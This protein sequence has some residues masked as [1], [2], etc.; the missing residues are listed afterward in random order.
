V[1]PAVD[2][3]DLR[4]GGRVAEEEAPDERVGLVRSISAAP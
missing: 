2:L 1:D 3:A 4:V